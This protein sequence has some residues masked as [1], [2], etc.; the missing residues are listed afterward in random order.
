MRDA[1]QETE[2]RKGALFLGSF[3]GKFCRWLGGPI[4]TRYWEIGGRTEDDKALGDF[5]DSD[6]KVTL[7]LLALYQGTSPMV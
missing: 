5:P 2:S 7:S 6:R 1:S 4:A 3:L